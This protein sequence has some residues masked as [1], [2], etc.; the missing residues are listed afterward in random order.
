MSENNENKEKLNNNEKGEEKKEET[1]DDDVDDEI[2]IRGETLSNTRIN[3]TFPDMNES[4]I[5]ARESV[6]F[7][8]DNLDLD[9]PNFS[10]PRYKKS[11]WKIMHG[12]CLLLFCLLFAISVPFIIIKPF[13]TYHILLIIAHVFYVLSTLVEWSYFNRGCIGDAN[14]NSKLK[15]NIDQSFRAK[16]LRG[17]SGLKYMICLFSS[18]IL[19]AGDSIYFV[20]KS[21]NLSIIETEIICDYFNIF[22]MMSI[23]LAQIMKLEKMLNEDNKISY[24]EYDFLKSLFEIFFFFAS[25]LDGGICTIHLFNMPIDKSPLNIFHLIIKALSGI[26]FIIS[27][28][29]LMINYFCN[30]L[31]KS[32]KKYRRM[33]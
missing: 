24:I 31:C 19:L 1:T 27:A 28:I 11:N 12:C 2:V 3:I 26:L 25:L 33:Y 6:A 13:R 23:A 17:E 7:R 5:P 4:N 18:L 22:G 14:L 20:T 30:D 8:Y 29:I 16:V 32:H 21:I 15:S 9:I 10:P